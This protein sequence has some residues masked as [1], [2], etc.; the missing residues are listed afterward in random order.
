LKLPT[1]SSARSASASRPTNNHAGA[2]PRFPRGE[3]T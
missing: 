2:D 3:P 1:S